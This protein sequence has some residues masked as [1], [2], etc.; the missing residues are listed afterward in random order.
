MPVIKNNYKGIS[1][2]PSLI[3]FLADFFNEKVLL[4][5]QSVSLIVHPSQY[6]DSKPLSRCFFWWWLVG[7]AA[8]K[9]IIRLLFIHPPIEISIIKFNSQNLVI[10]LNKVISLGA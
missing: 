3:I 10:S 7:I 2:L 5:S 9:F 1:L 8:G 4:I 6:A